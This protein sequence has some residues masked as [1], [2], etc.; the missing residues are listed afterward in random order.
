MIIVTGTGG[1][2]QL[3][4]LW[5]GAVG[6][7]Y[8]SRCVPFELRLGFP[9]KAVLQLD[10]YSLFVVFDDP[11]NFLLAPSFIENAR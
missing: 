8:L 6:L 5:L 11:S 4:D 9:S 3:G 7:M 10:V 1:K 2:C